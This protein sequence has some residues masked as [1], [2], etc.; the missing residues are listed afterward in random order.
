MSVE[1]VVPFNSN[2]AEKLENMQQSEMTSILPP[3][4]S[5]DEVCKYL[6]LGKTIVYEMIRKHEIP[7]LRI[8]NRIRISA[9][10][11]KEYLDAC[12]QPNNKIL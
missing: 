8:R 2:L 12:R 3:L 11:L 7:H 6:G 1:K 5:I 10:D 4:L 9:A